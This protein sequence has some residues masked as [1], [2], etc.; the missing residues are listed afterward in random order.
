MRISVTSSIVITVVSLASFVF[1]IGNTELWSGESKTKESNDEFQNELDNVAGNQK[2][3]NES[4][5]AFEKETSAIASS[6]Q[7]EAGREAA[8]QARKAYEPIKT[9][10]EVN[11]VAKSRADALLRRAESS[12]Q[13]VEIQRSDGHYLYAYQ[14]TW[15]YTRYREGAWS[16]KEDA[17]KNGKAHAQL[18][19]NGELRKASY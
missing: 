6:R 15:G 7:K 2:P 18:L 19:Y 12:L 16:T 1:F 17:Y 11:P 4:G 14:L 8:A 10:D 9:M 13:L 3:S 5:D